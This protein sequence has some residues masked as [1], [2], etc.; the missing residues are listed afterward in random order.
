MLAFKSLRKTEALRNLVI[1]RGGFEDDLAS[2]A[3]A[4]LDRVYDAGSRIRRHHQPV[5]Q[6][7]DGLAKIYVE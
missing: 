6:Q 5:H 7:K 3:I 2:F 1:T 4:D